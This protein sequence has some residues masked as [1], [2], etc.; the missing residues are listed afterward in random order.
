MVEGD[1]QFW[2]YFS[3]DS[4]GMCTGSCLN[5]VGQ[6]W[7]NSELLYIFYLW[8]DYLDNLFLSS[9]FKYGGYSVNWLSMI[10]EL[11]MDN[12]CLCEMKG[13]KYLLCVLV[14]GEWKILFLNVSCFHDLVYFLDK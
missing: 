13:C 7:K 14:N 4:S 12:S 9:V 10:K 11:G 6:L 5:L 3:V 2:E 1:I 8:I